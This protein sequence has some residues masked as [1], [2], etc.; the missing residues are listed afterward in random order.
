MSIKSVLDKIGEDAKDVF[1]FLG[2]PKGQTLVQAGEGIV[3]AVVPGATGAVNL[4][5]N[6]LTEILKTQALA[7]AAAA[8]TGSS[9]Q[10]AALVLQ[11]IGPQAVQ[12]AQVN[13]VSVPTAA[14][15]NTVNSLLVQALNAFTETV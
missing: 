4:F 14:T 3:E 13:G 8:P 10:K 7:T 15:L 9:T 12:F 1:T 2:S 11:A 5:N 6:W